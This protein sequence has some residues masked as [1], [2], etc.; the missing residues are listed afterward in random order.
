MTKYW[1]R[2]GAASLGALLAVAPAFAAQLAEEKSLNE[3]RNTVVNLLQA[4]VQKGVMTQEQAEALVQ[5]AQTKAAQDATAAAAQEAAREKE[6]A[7]A[8]RVPYVPEIV[9]EEIRNQVA[10]EVKPQVVK[11]VLATAHS[12]KWGVPGA[13]PTWVS[14]LTLSGDIRFR[15]QSD[16][17][18]SDNAR[19]AYLDFNTINSKG[20][21]GKAGTAAFLNTNEN[22]LRSRVRLRLELDERVTDGVMAGIR[23][24]SGS[25]TGP[26][27]TNQTLGQYGGRYQFSLDRVYLRFDANPHSD[28]PWMTLWGGR[29]P[30]PWVST[31]LV[32]HPDLQ[33]EGFAG[34]W[35]R[36][37]GVAGWTPRNAF[38]TLGAFPLQEIALSRQDN[39]WLYG[40]QLGL[41]WPT[42]SGARAR[43]AAAYYYFN[44][45]TGIRNAPDSTLLN[46][47]AP[48]FL[49]KG[50]TLFDISNSTDPTVNLFALAAQYHLLDVTASLELPVFEHRVLFLADYV[51][52]LGY[53]TNDVVRRIGF[54]SINDVPEN[55]RLLYV[56]RA[57]GYK[58]EIG[59][60]SSATGT[61]GDWLAGIEYRYLE[62]DAVVDAFTDS[63]FHLGGTGAKGYVLKGDW[64]FLDRTWLSLRYFSANEINHTQT[65]SDGTTVGD[66]PPF[67]VDTLMID[68]NGQF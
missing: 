52:N 22:E 23:L 49:Q 64:W 32:W 19:N 7:G 27:S 66:A 59:F 35:R 36:G 9:K 17:F 57:S 38:L 48:P 21:I 68:V 15:E 34:T 63:D 44:H 5:Q 46:F 37:L 12:E 62:R 55:Q 56:K 50:N 60:G 24:T 30:N 33:F 39:K 53:N 6:E 26:I 11:E 14:G 42:V 2:L 67:G 61:R 13:L 20:G 51:N 47:T 18:A 45:I 31:D 16:W 28:L 65:L 25:Q 4:L 8:V 41:D 3:L 54:A 29:M 1:L 10:Q 58:A 43:I 40:G